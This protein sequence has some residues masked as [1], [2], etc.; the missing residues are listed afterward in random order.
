MSTNYWKG[1]YYGL[2]LDTN[3]K[4]W[5]YNKTLYE[6]AGI[7]TPPAT[8]EE[9]ESQ[10]QTL[11]A[12]N[13]DAYY[14]AA[15]G[16]FAW[17]TLPWIWSFGGALTDPDVTTATGFLNGPDTVAAYEF[18]LKL[19]DQG[20]ISP[21]ILGNGVDPFTGFAQDQYANLDN[22]P[23]T[24]PIVA[25]QFPEK[26]IFAAPFPAGKGGSIDVVG[27]EDVVLFQQSQHKEQAIEFIRFLVSEEYQMKM[28]E[29]GQIPVRVDLVD[30]DYFTSHP[31]YSYF[32]EQLKTSQSRTAHPNWSKMD[33]ILTSAGQLILR[34]E[35]TPQEALDEAAAKIDA[36]LK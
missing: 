3:T 21:V 25:S 7:S 26:E 9:L 4:V 14:F 12:A 32:L 17:V 36:L 11:K 2:P 35:K 6:A 30:S 29:V 15:D 5:L 33:E 13:P 22:G 34:H 8:M 31:Y 1:H 20:C 23:W 19:Y 16:T 24:Y 28:A 18:L 10:C 27:G